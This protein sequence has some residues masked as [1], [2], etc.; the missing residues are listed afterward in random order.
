MKVYIYF[1][2]AGFILAFIGVLMIILKKEEEPKN[3]SR[4]DFNDIELEYRDLKNQ[5]LELIKEFNRS[6]HFNTELLEDK[7]KSLN[8]KIDESDDRLLKFNK[9]NTD[10]D[11]MYKKM[12]DLVENNKVTYNETKELPKKEEEVSKANHVIKGIED[13]ILE[14][15]KQGLS[16]NEIAE[17][18][19]KSVGELEFMMGLGKLR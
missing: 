4:S 10:M 13:E 3:V 2:I 7:I 6:A 11:I 12:V 1:I 9:M 15:K 17:K 14:Y 5:V 16:I 8:K 19:G 18:T